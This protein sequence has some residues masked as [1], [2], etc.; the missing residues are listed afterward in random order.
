MVD[1]PM[2][3]SHSISTYHFIAMGFKKS[4]RGW[5]VVDNVI[6]SIVN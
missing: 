4:M 6:T 3:E 1:I 2:D 5:L